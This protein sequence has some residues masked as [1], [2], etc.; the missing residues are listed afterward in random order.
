[1]NNSQCTVGAAFNAKIGGVR[2]LDGDVSDVIEAKSIG[3]NPSHI[4]IYSA[5]WGPDDNGKVVDG[6]ARLAKKAFVNGILKGRGGKGSIY[7]WASGNGGLAGDSCNCDG[8]TNSIYTLSIS[9]ADEHGRTPWYLEQCSSTLATTYS[10]GDQAKDRQI[11][12]TDLH[13]RCTERHTGTSA[14][15]PMAAGICALALEANPDLGWRDM[16][17]I[18]LLTA[19]PEPLYDGDWTVNAK[20]RKVSLKYGYGLMDAAAMVELAEQWTPVPDH[21]ICMS[22]LQTINRHID[23]SGLTVTLDHTA[24]DEGSPHHI[25]YL[26]HVQAKVSLEYSQRGAL[27]MTIISPSGTR[28]ELLKQRLKDDASGEFR[29]WPFMSV[30]FWGEDPA[31]IWTLEIEN[32]GSPSNSGT[33]KEWRIIFYGTAEQPINIQEPRKKSTDDYI[34]TAGSHNRHRGNAHEKENESQSTTAQPINDQG[35]TLDKSGKLLGDQAQECHPECAH[36]C[37]GPGP[38]DC[39][40]CMNFRGPGG[41]CISKCGIGMYAQGG[42]CLQCSSNCASCK[43]FN[44]CLR[45][46]SGYYIDKQ[47]GLCVKT[48]SSGFYADKV[49][50]ACVRCNP[51]CLECQE[52]ASMCTLCDIGETLGGDGICRSNCPY[53][54]YRNRQNQCKPCDNT[55]N[56]CTGPTSKDCVKCV[57]SLNGEC[58]NACPSGYYQPPN[59][60]ECLRCHSSCGT[61]RGPQDTDCTRCN[62]N[63]V[64]TDGACRLPLPAP[65]PALSLISCNGGEYRGVNGACEVCHADCIHCTG[66]TRYD[67]TQCAENRFLDQTVGCVQTCPDGY[68]GYVNRELVVQECQRCHQSCFTCKGP[69]RGDCTKCHEGQYLDSGVC[70][71]HCGSGEFQIVDGTCG[72]CHSSCLNCHGP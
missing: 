50:G 12:T 39:M 31:G 5:S 13:H 37:S 35:E 22:P 59:G 20:G 28:S 41:R 60:F 36:G 32:L 44:S 64:L 10:S 63:R 48:C 54:Q 24:C 40:D 3:L 68:F 55:C 38:D 16:Q 34:D 61:C 45:C 33:F 30:H 51:N 42:V 25:K 65:E 49:M 71:D 58:Y 29:D 19:R 1:A 46:N 56:G 66:G 7:V 9:S 69:H 21:H 14:S 70:F 43:S 57:V 53:N 6:P 27:A 15:A 47:S 67:C 62:D 72:R 26:E 8:Y 18:T 4:D 23:G 52:K 11:V 2:M 17:Y